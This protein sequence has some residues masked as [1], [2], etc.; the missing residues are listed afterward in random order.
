M[1]SRLELRVVAHGFER[2]KRLA[3][4]E[5]DA[6][7]EQFSLLH[8]ED[9]RA[10]D[11]DAVGLEVGAGVGINAEASCGAP[12]FEGERHGRRGISAPGRQT[13][14]RERG[15]EVGHVRS[16]GFWGC[17]RRGGERARFDPPH[18]HAG[19]V[20]HGDPARDAVRVRRLQ[21]R[22]GDP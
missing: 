21:Q 8:L 5:F 4:R 10:V 14:Q 11:V 9:Q 1:R 16:T 12:G 15:D 17:R 2:E 3:R 7:G 18:L 13:G 6:G 19:L 20:P 22:H